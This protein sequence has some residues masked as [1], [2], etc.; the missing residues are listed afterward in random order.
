MPYINK[1]LRANLDEAIKGLEDKIKNCGTE[2]RAGVL[3][4]C[5]SKMFSNLFSLRYSEINEAIGVLECSKLEFYRRVAVPYE[6]KKV[7]DN[8]DVYN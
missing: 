2:N 8:G 7:I 4:Y 1:D 3:N 5:I 6:D